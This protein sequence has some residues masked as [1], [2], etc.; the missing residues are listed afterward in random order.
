MVEEWSVPAWAVLAV[1]TAALLVVLLGLV[2]AVRGRARHR[3]E[4]E[5]AQAETSALQ[6]RLT[7]LERRLP[8]PGAV[9][10]SSARPVEEF[11]ITRAGEPEPADDG[12]A[13]A[14]RA[15]LFA[16]LVL[17][18]SVVQAASLTAGLRRALS[19]A[20]RNRIR[21]E[22]KQEVRRSRKQRRADLR[23]ARR[24]WEARQRG[25]LDEAAEGSAA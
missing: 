3:R 12:R 5:R 23:A 8:E 25:G 16:D 13:P 15:P 17:R 14:V 22:V 21:F 11:V 7:A 9:P 2:L 4:L 1:A 6:D 24:D 20:T 18:E 19:P 10:T